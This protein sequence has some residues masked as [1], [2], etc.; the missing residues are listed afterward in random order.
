[1]AAGADFTVTKLSAVIQPKLATN[2][3]QDLNRQIQTALKGV[4]AKALVKV[5]LSLD[6][7][8]I[9]RVQR[10]I[11]SGINGTSVKVKVDADTSSAVRNVK[12]TFQEI[13]GSSLKMSRTISTRINKELNDAFILRGE[14]SSIDKRLKELNRQ[15]DK[16]LAA[17]R[18]LKLELD[19]RGLRSQLDVIKKEL[20]AIDKD[21]KIKATVNLDGRTF[22]EA[23]RQLIRNVNEQFKRGLKF[24]ASDDGGGFATAAKSVQTLGT[25]FGRMSDLAGVAGVV[26]EG[27]SKGISFLGK[28]SSVAAEGTG[29]LG[30]SF[31]RVAGSAAA[32]V[33]VGALNVAV[34]ALVA[35]L[36]AGISAAVGFSATAVILGGIVTAVAV[37]IS[38]LTAAVTVAV[39]ALGGLAAA[40]GVVA[41]AMAPVASAFQE[42][43]NTQSD[44][45]AKTGATA[46]AANSLA[47]AMRSAESAVR[48]A[49][50][51][52]QD[53]KRNVA[54]AAQ[55]I[56]DAARSLRN[57]KEAAVDAA[58]GVDQ[59]KRALRNAGEAVAEAIRGV[60]DAQRSL[61]DAGQSV[62]DAQQGII[63]AQ[64]G[65]RDAGEAVSDALRGVTKAEEA[66]AKAS[67]R[68]LEAQ[69]GVTKALRD[70]Q[71]AGE[72]VTKAQ[73]NYQKAGDNVAKAQ[74]RHQKARESLTKAEE[75]AKENLIELGRAARDAAGKEEDAEIRLIRAREKLAGLNPLEN[76]QTDY[77]EAL[78]D[79]EQAERDLSD[80]RED[81]VGTIKEFNDAQ[82]KGIAGSDEVKDAQQAI[83]D[84]AQAVADAQ[85]EQA[86]A[87]QAIADARDAEAEALANIAEAQKDVA[88]AI[89]DR[90][91]AEYDLGQAKLGVRDAIEAQAEAQRNLERAQRDLVSAIEN[92]ADAEIGVEDAKKRVR[93]AI[94][95]QKDAQDAVNDALLRERDA[96]EAIGDAERDLQRAKEDHTRAIELQ[97]EAQLGLKD[98][99]LKLNET[100]QNGLNTT[101]Q[102]TASQRKFNQAFSE[103]TPIGQQFVEKLKEAYGWVKNLQRI[104]QDS[105]LPGLGEAMTKVIDELGGIIED[106]VRKIGT[107]VGGLA[108]DISNILTSPQMKDSF[109]S[110]VNTANDSL[111]QIGG[112]FNDFI[113]Q[114]VPGLAALGE[115]SGPVTT[116]VAN[117][118]RE[119]GASFSYLFAQLAKPEVQEAMASTVKGIVDTLGFFV[120]AIGDFSAQTAKAMKKIGPALAENLGKLVNGLFAVMS[121]FVNSGLV[122]GFLTFVGD[123][124]STL[125]E[126][127]DG[128]FIREFGAA[129]GATLRVL[130]KGISDLFK[131]PK[132][133]QSFVDLFN[134]MPPLIKALVEALPT[135]LPAFLDFV[136]VSSKFTKDFGPEI[137]KGIS[138]ALDVLGVAINLITPAFQSVGIAWDLLM[139]AFDLGLGVVK[140]IGAVLYSVG[141]NIITGLI[142][143]VTAGWRFVTK[144]F[145]DVFNDL[146]ELVKDILG[147]SSPSRV[148]M[149]IG[150]FLVEGLLNAVKATWEFV[151]NFFSS[152]L[153]TL[154]TFFKDSFN[155]LVSSVRAI[156]STIQRVLTDI[157]AAVVTNVWNPI[158]DFITK[159]VPGW[160]KDGVQ[161][162]KD[163]WEYLSTVIR[164]TWD[165]ITSKEGPLGKVKTFVLETIPGWF[166]S[167]VSAVEKAWAKVSGVI[168]EVWETV[169]KSVWNPIKTFIVDTI[170]G[171]F[172]TGVEAITSVWNKMKKALSDPVVAIVD[173]VYNDGIRPLWNNIVTKIPGVKEIPQLAFKGLATGGTVDGLLPGNSGMQ[174]K[175]DRIARSP[176]GN[177]ALAGGEY[178]VNAPAV[179]KFGVDKLEA[180]NSGRPVAGF[181]EGGFIGGLKDLLDEGSDTVRGALG[182]LVE[183]GAG[184]ARKLLPKVD[185]KRGNTSD[186]V[187]SVPAGV[188]DQI[189]SFVKSDDKANPPLLGDGSDLPPGAGGRSYNLGRVEEQT[190]N[191]AHYLGNLFGIKTIGGYGPG[192]VPGS[193]HPAGRGLDFMTNNLGDP[194]VSH[195]TGDKLSKF[196]QQNWSSLN[197]KYIIWDKKYIGSPGQSRGYS[198][199]SD[200]TD[201][202]HMSLLPGGKFTAPDMQTGGGNAD[203]PRQGGALS[204]GFRN[205]MRVLDQAGFNFRYSPGQLNGGKH[206]TTSWHYKDRAIDIG[207]GTNGKAQVDKAFDFL[208]KNYG[209]SSK[210]L[211]YSSE[212]VNYKNGNKIGPFPDHFDHI[213]WAYNKGGKVPGFANG[214]LV[215]GQGGPIDDKI[216]AMLSNGEFV[217]NAASTQKYLP[218]LNQINDGTFRPFDGADSE[219]L[220]M[221]VSVFKIS[222]EKFATALDGVE[223]KFSDIPEMVKLLS[224][225]FSNELGQVVAKFKEIHLELIDQLK[226]S[227]VEMTS[228]FA[229]AVSEFRAAIAG[230]GSGGSGGEDVTPPDVPDVGTP[231]TETPI[232]PT[233]FGPPKNVKPVKGGFQHI[234]D[235]ANK[236][237]PG[238]GIGKAPSRGNIG[239]KPLSAQ[240]SMAS[241]NMNSGQ[242]TIQD[243]SRKISMVN[244]ITNS[245][246][247]VLMTNRL[248]AML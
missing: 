112:A 117:G 9:K 108:V 225:Q 41:L 21:G 24:K 28:I 118:L 94:E 190:R 228:G 133:I 204:P 46:K 110:L 153:T 242:P 65:I 66:L 148:F 224:S 60:A 159:T 199:P 245:T 111:K 212:P 12:N 120:R 195:P 134:E 64:I 170:P 99:I 220:A 166:S 91:D 18:K 1:M 152:A 82:A 31:S 54:D 17:D 160:F 126:M 50:R 96:R 221:F 230:M 10:Q 119:L 191:V 105:L 3:K 47:A 185:T 137:I 243:N 247:A 20:R 150:K 16:E 106:G 162:V 7:G 222:V 227:N 48:A 63:D 183:K 53:A 125:Q 92:Q 97:K 186:L 37:G 102:S 5:E 178:V 216:E 130:G 144:L 234:I 100:R 38:A 90:A 6:Q 219:T 196:I 26:V 36:G 139:K 200:H 32:S 11:D 194:K 161:Y 232:T 163:K 131:D 69:N 172:K 84:A 193:D 44:T 85:Q 201:H 211:F 146:I 123:L 177:I 51:G 62:V 147:I 248:N 143:S 59:A 70:Y 14:S 140:S 109:T 101:D 198:G 43:V 165:Y 135:L 39:G 25:A 80:I 149:E 89:A 30:T 176:Y 4:Q 88:D 154:I 35:A 238:L 233:P 235:E 184:L 71:R 72:A 229:S 87:L 197:T 231:G 182:S 114:V 129:M 142:D 236:L 173:T 132:V 136:T 103:L 128:G 86:D 240:T 157:W 127:A 156:F 124:G 52:L 189:V 58:Q 116:A 164:L 171:W 56:L 246:E 79:V 181:A 45:P 61:R 29:E 27:V 203:T 76:D 74:A 244:H 83:A 145:S 107:T 214:G 169:K 34:I 202:V 175:D 210:E 23:A 42:F 68:I 40:A 15:I 241:V 180:I 115:A 217:V 239:V 75:K 113:A 188:L 8:S 155:T 206:S 95:S 207:V 208:A 151:K 138:F 187:N 13:E 33:A 93:D 179:K 167:A 78:R 104:A 73:K 141:E 98:A 122:D 192:S 2:F 168:N 55:G 226:A 121:Q 205:Q 158:R 57:A 19:D 237:L 67:E 218:Q 22:E 174:F 209:R 81:N 77:R 223:Q 49:S 213:H 215:T